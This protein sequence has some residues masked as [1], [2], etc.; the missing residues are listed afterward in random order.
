[1]PSPKLVP[2]VLSDAERASLEALSRKRTASQSLAE[3][4]RV[5]LACADE[6]GVAPLTRVAARTGLS[7]ESVRKWRVR[8][9]E[10]RMDGLG[11]APRPGAA[12][13][14]TDE[15]VEVLVTR[16]LTEKGRGQ[17]SHWSTRSMAAE[18]GL[19]QSS[20]SRIWRAFG[21]KPHVVETWKLS[22]DPEF[23]GKVRDVVGLYMSPAGERPG[24]VRGREVADPGPG[25]DR[26]RACRCCRRPRPG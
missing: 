22:T 7:R 10:R 3:R 2:L 21:L 20:V 8:F 14:I 26:A 18:T 12:R 19:S 25:P 23:I 6:G 5:V 15:Q 4:A 17:D 11:D 1:M 24:P 13:K 16:T 9:M